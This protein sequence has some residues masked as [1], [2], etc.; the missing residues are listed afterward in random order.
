[1]IA[2]EADTD[3]FTTTR[4]SD[5]GV[6]KFDQIRVRGDRKRFVFSNY[7]APTNTGDPDWEGFFVPAWTTDDENA[8]IDGAT[9][10]LDTACYLMAQRSKPTLERESVYSS[11]YAK[12]KRNLK[13]DCLDG[14]GNAVFGLDED[15]EPIKPA[16]H[17]ILVQPELPL[18]QLVDYAGSFETIDESGGQQKNTGLVPNLLWLHSV[19][20]S[21]RFNSRDF[22]I[23][24]SGGH[25]ND[26][27]PF[28][29]MKCSSKMKAKRLRSK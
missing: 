4:L 22:W 24:N 21:R 7:I 9:G 13:W 5:S 20:K 6:I 16:P 3:P 12:Y 23:L 18:Y 1:M 29:E 10:R 2:I 17:T 19:D 26:E 27:T 14:A 8:Y 28:P 25:S 11:V 15:D